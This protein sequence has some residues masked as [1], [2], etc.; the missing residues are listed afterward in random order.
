MATRSAKQP[1]V[2]LLPNRRAAAGP[3]EEGRH[4]SRALDT[5]WTESFVLPKGCI[6]EGTFRLGASPRAAFPG[7]STA[8]APTPT[9]TTAQRS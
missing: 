7:H 2:R 6:G 1:H 5:R 3:A 8:H 4:Q 9:T